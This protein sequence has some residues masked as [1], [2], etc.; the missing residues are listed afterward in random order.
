[1]VKPVER[2][3]KRQAL[4]IIIRQ[5]I[6]VSL[7]SILFF[8]VAGQTLSFSILMG[9]LSYS[10]PDLLFVSRFLRYDG[11]QMITGSLVSFFAGKMVELVLRG[12]LV[13]IVIIY[14]P[15][16]PLWVCIGFMSCSFIFWAAC[17]MQFRERQQFTES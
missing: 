9:G 13:L 3:I 4:A 12:I 14:L 10:L 11:I 2:H 1:M 8:L 16:N 7:L 17:M 15:V 5:L 6:G